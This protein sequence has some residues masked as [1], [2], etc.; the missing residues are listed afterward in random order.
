M[1]VCVCVCTC[2]CVCMCGSKTLLCTQTLLGSLLRHCN[3]LAVIDKN[4]LND[5]LVL[6]VK[7]I[8]NGVLHII[9]HIDLYVRGSF[10][11]VKP[12]LVSK[13]TWS[14]LASLMWISL[15]TSLVS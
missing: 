1:C 14:C 5:L 12:A 8:A 15:K 10:L 11:T 9:F 13:T 7:H 3:L 6:T 2:V 4:K